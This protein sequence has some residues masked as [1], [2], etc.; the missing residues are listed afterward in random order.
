MSQTF[1]GRT[2]GKQVC[3]GKRTS[4]SRFIFENKHCASKNVHFAEV[5]FGVVGM[6]AARGA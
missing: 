6:G 5:S 4:A 1:K 3:E 2:T